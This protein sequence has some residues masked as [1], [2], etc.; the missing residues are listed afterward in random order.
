[1]GRINLRL[2]FYCIWLRLFYRRY[3]RILF[4]D[5]F[6][7]ISGDMNLGALIDLG[8]DPAKLEA[9]L[10]KLGLDG[11]ELKIKK[12]SRGGIFGTQVSV[13]CEECGH[14]HDAHHGNEH[15][16]AHSHGHHSHEDGHCACHEH[17]GHS[18]GEHAHE[19]SEHGNEEHGH[20]HHH[21]HRSFADIKKIIENSAL[22]GFAKKKSLAVFSIL[23]EAEGRVHGKS[24]NEVHFHEVGAVDSIVDIVGAAICLELLNVDK[25]V[26]SAVELGGGTVKCRHGVMPVPA[27]ATAVLAEKFPSKLGGAPHECTT[28]TGA[29]IIAA[30]ADGFESRAV[31]RLAATGIGVGHRDCPEL[32]NVLRVMLYETPEGLGGTVLEAM[33]ELSANIDDMTAER[34]AYFCEKLFEAG[35]RDVW[36]ESICMKKGRLAVKVCALAPDAAAAKVRECFFAHSSTLGVREIS[37]MRHSIERNVETVKTSLGEVR[38]KRWKFDGMERFKPEFEDCK[39]I[40]EEKGMTLDGVVGKISNELCGGKS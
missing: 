22:S 31:G 12:D 39:K 40:A 3:M 1:M 38:V 17:E 11:W 6:A 7:G 13:E 16:C 30:L 28:P 4:Y 19:H 34:V 21:E 29:A 32:A 10:K 37:I 35:A 27:P 26:S 24:P 9:E 18:H 15:E 23:A 36:Q 25:I 2:I 14:S 33:S 8:V 20:R 5:C